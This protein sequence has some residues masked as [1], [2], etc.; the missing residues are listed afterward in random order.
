MTLQL[1]NP[2]KGL[3]FQTFPTSY[4]GPS[5]VCVCVCVYIYIWTTSFTSCWFPLSSGLQAP[6]LHLNK[7]SPYES[8]E[9]TA[10]CS[11]PEEK[12]SLVFRFYQKFRTGDP[13]RIKQTAATGNSSETTL[14]LRSIG[15][16]VLYCDYE[17][18]LVSGARRSN[19]SN[20]ITVIVKGY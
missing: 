8:E 15:D 3:A 16:S 4:A 18:N 1:I 11:A 19:R 2:E 17:V 10:V 20:E 6:I 14:V 12:G 5:C 7:T 13:Q 9:F